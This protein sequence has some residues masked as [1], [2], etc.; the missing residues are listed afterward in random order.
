MNWFPNKW[1]S[2]KVGLE[3]ICMAQ[4]SLKYVRESATD[5]YKGHR[6]VPL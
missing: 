1:E 5:I 2:R 6:D 4:G 3:T